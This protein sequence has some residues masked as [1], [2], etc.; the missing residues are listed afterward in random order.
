VPASTSKVVTMTTVSNTSIVSDPIDQVSV[1]HPGRGKVF[2][3]AETYIKKTAETT[4]WTPNEVSRRVKSEALRTRLNATR[5]ITN[6]A[7]TAHTMISGTAIHHDAQP[8]CII[9]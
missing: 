9:A 5:S 7:T 6:E 8:C 1:T 3:E 2:T 4:K